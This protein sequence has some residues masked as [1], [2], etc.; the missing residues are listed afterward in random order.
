MELIQQCARNTITA[1]RHPNPCPIFMR[2]FI[3][4]FTTTISSR[5]KFCAGDINRH[6]DH[7]EAAPRSCAAPIR[8][9]PSKPPC[10]NLRTPRAAGFSLR[11]SFGTRALQHCAR[12]FSSPGGFKRLFTTACPVLPGPRAPVSYLAISAPRGQ[13]CLD[14]QKRRA[15]RRSVGG[16]PCGPRTH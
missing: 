5:T 10:V 6:Q 11:E 8:A 15:E 2:V 7:Q 14:T 16:K 3:R 1:S 13:A 9:R 4:S 12:S